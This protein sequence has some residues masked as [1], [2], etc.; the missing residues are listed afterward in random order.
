MKL[1]KST[2][3]IA[4]NVWLLLIIL[5]MPICSK[6]Q[7]LDNLQWG[8][9]DDGL[10]LSI[11]KIASGKTNFPEFQVALR[12]VGEK[13][14]TVN[15]GVML[16]NGKKQEPDKIKFILTDAN[17]K[18]HQFNFGSVIMMVDGRLDDFIVPLRAGSMYTLKFSSDESTAQLLAGKYKITAEFEGIGANLTN[19]DTQ[20]IKLMNFWLGK[21]KSNELTV[22]R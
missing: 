14:T 13:D 9:T 2:I 16:A 5:L 12:N 4:G 18:T 15:L 6:A 21:L 20:G 22:E 7:S 17:G 1:S 11:S 3:Y 8:A 10:Q 19:L